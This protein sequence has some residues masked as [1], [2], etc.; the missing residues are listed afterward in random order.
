MRKRLALAA[1]FTAAALALG[2]CSGGS[3]S[4]GNTP[5]PQP[6]KARTA[7]FT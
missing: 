3:G 6:E 2:G 1:G 5:P 4:A 7:P